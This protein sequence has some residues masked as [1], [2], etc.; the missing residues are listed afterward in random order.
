[1]NWAIS[2]FSDRWAKAPIARRPDWARL[3]DALTTPD[4]VGPHGT[5]DHLPLWSPA[6]YPDGETRGAARV[7]SLSMLVLDYD[8][9]TLIEEALGAWCQWPGVLHTSFSHKPSAPKF[10]V[11]LPLSAPVP[12]AHWPAVWRWAWRTAAKKIDSK[13]KDAS[14]CYYMPAARKA[15]GAFEA[16]AWPATRPT[17][18]LGD[19]VPWAAELSELTKPKPPPVPRPVIQVSA[20]RARRKA[21][22]RLDEDPHSRLSLARA[23]GAELLGDPPIARRIACPSCARRDVWFAVHPDQSAWAKCNHAKTCG[24]W[25][26]LFNLARDNGWQL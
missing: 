10:R 8:D 2:L 9:G 5:K 18:F 14:R 22:A 21:K 3:V 6:Q 15:G 1:M 20:G 24:W 25:G 16:Y 11:V 4:I 23:L 7:Q 12:A 19:A 13:C 26:D 17:V